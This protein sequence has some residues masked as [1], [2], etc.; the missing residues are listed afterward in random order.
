MATVAELGAREQVFIGGE[1]VEPSGAE[2]IAVVN[3]TSEE[4]IA[5]VPGCTPV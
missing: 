4:T 1:W 5:T 2:P 3:P